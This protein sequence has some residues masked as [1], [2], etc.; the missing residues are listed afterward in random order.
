VRWNWLLGGNDGMTMELQQMSWESGGMHA[1]ARRLFPICRSLTGNGVREML[2][3]LQEYLP[4]LVI[5]EVP[6]GTRCLDWVVPDEWNIRSAKLTGPDGEVI[7]DFAVSNLHVVGYSEPVDR[8]LS[9][10]ELQPHLHSLSK[11]PTAIPYVTSY[12]NRTWGFCLAHEVR[13]KLKAGQYRAVIDSTLEPGSLTYGEL[14]LPGESEDEIFFSTY[15]CHPSM[16]NNELSGPVVSTWLARYLQS[17]ASRRHSVRI[18]FVPET[19]GSI[20]YL[21]R[22]LEHLKQHV[23]AG[24]VVTCV[25]DDRSYSYVASRAADTL[26]D[27]VAKHVLGHRHPGYVSYSYLKRGSDER[28]YCWP[29]VDLPVCSVIRSK[30]GAYPEYHTSLDNLALI[31][32]AGMQGALENLQRCFECVEACQRYRTTVIGEPQMGR[33]H[34]Y[35]SISMKDARGPSVRRMV[36]ILA[37]SDGKLDLLEI[38][39]V[40]GVPMWEII[41]DVQILV[42]EGLLEEVV[43]RT[44]MGV[45]KK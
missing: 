5:H 2:Q 22:H 27:R 10:E 9:L 21:S 7:A 20:V 30:Y 15:I 28:N 44:K 11:Q 17:R 45:A 39:E 23:L 37:Y 3:I 8:T 19:I 29:G 16:G 42:R 32:E 40:L 41:D 33:R 36:D 18:L 1:L 25:G 12:Y 35:P 31:S 4:E 34:L 14:I 24:Y 43:D 38:A 6:T 13:E 26:A